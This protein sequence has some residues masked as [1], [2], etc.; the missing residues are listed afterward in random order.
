MKV[1]VMDGVK[2]EGLKPLRDYQ[3]IELVIGSKMTEDELCEAIGEYEGIIVRSATKV[4]AKVLE[5]ANKLKVVGRAGVGVDNIDLK[6]ASEKGIMV[7]NAPDG[8]TIAACELTVGMMFCLARSIPQA[9]NRTIKDKV[10]DKKAFMG[11]ELRG[12][13][14]GVIG[15]GRIGSAVAKRALA[16]EMK[17]YGYDPFVYAEKAKDL[18]IELVSLDELFAKADMITIHMPKTTT[19]YHMINDETIAKMK[20]GV[21][22]LNCAR[23]GIIEEEALYKAMV[24]GKIAGAGLDVF[25]IEP[26]EKSPL[27]ELPNFIATPH[28]G[29]STKEAQLKVAVDVA[30]EIANALTGKPVNNIVNK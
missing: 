4:T 3:E 1:L 26:N 5:K 6:A 17:V 30:V 14:L 18:G 8:N 2:E 13:N 19:T 29:A 20:D 21:Y 12:K 16:L 15:L 24:A 27:L 23:G 11:F 10:W 25:E 28:I 7:V 9:I 22:I